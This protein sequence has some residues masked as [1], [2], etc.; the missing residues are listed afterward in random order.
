PWLIADMPFGS[1]HESPAQA[2]RNAVALMQA[3]AQMVKLEGGAELAGIIK[4]FVQAGI[5]V[6]AHVGLL[7][8]HVHAI[9]GF[10]VQGRE[11]AHAERILADARALDAAGAAMMVIEG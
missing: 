8:Q 6:C 9:G 3:G 1:Y 11:A 2:M 5:P 7:P 10:R 4:Q